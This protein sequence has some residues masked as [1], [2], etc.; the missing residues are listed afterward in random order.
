MDEETPTQ[1]RHHTPQDL[2]TVAPRVLKNRFELLEPLGQGGMGIVYKA[3]DYQRRRSK[4]PLVHVAL[5]VLS[6][7]IQQHPD[8]V[9]AL[10]REFSRTLQLTHPN[11]VRTYDFDTDDAQRV[12]FLTMELLQGETVEAILERHPAGLPSAQYVPWVEQLLAGLECAHQHGIVHSDLKPGNLFITQA[13]QLK[14]MDFGIA[15]PLRPLDD[16]RPGTL[17]D[18]RKLGALSPSHACVEMFAGMSAD[19]RDDLYSLGCVVYQLVSG[20]HPF[21]GK[22]APDALEERLPVRPLPALSESANEA[23]RGALAFHRVDRIGSVAEFRE[24]FFDSSSTRVARSAWRWAVPLGAAV[25][26][27]AVIG[28]LAWQSNRSGTEPV[29]RPQIELSGRASDAP[30]ARPPPA[31][32]IEPAKKTPRETAQETTKPSVAETLAPPTDMASDDTAFERYCGDKPSRAALEPLLQ[33]GYEAQ[34]LL[35]LA[36]TDAMRTAEGEKLARFA[37][38]IGALRARQISTAESQAFLADAA[39][40]QKKIAAP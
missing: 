29:A 32:D 26:S 35:T 7:S 34:A 16:P 19:P 2:P 1:R 18:P 9:L 33:R 20:H 27:A 12:S 25:V 8:A 17:F 40:L 24:R 5:K 28:A 21:R 14:I 13:Q 31:K 4:D 36:S 38:C 15:A 39:A 3:L 37:D 30:V 22:R 11:I 10:Q 6:E 23:L